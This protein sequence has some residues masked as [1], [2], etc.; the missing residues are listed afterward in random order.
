VKSNQIPTTKL[1]QPIPVFNVD[2]TAN[3]EGS[4]SEVAE[5]LLHY[6][7]HSERALLCVTG[8][9]KQN[10]ILG[11]TWLK[12]HNP[13]VDL[14]TG[15]V[16]MSCCSPRCNG[17]R[18]K[19]REERR[20]LKR[21]AA[22]IN[23]CRSGSFPATVEDAED[24]D[25][26]DDEPAASDIPFDIEEGDCVWATGLIPEAQYIQATSTISQRLAEGFAR[27][28]EINPTLP[29]RGSVRVTSISNRAYCSCQ[30]C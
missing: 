11:H 15:K 19:A 27:N 4:I 7:G 25:A 16:E 5:L 13:E 2:G 6:N 17:C 1:S 18:T 30:V 26:S 12:E 8:L 20:I 29:T 14:R 9:E 23:A 3:T 10:L 21:E 22:S 24:E 28:S